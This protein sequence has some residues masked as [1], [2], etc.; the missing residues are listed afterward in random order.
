[1]GT[2]NLGLSGA[3]FVRITALRDFHSSTAAAAAG[4]AQLRECSGKEAG[5]EGGKRA[6][7]VRGPTTAASLESPVWTK[8]ARQTEARLLS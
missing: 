6:R 8:N 5:E 2:L 3:H 4:H 1:M 7:E